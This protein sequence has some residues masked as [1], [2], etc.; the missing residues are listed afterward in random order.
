[1]FGIP[2][3]G[4]AMSLILALSSAPE[5]VRATTLYQ[6]GNSLTV[7]S[8]LVGI[9]AIAGLAG[10][11][12]SG[13]R[14]VVS[15]STLGEIWNGSTID[16][17]SSPSA[18][19]QQGLAGSLLDYVT[20]Q[21][22]NKGTTNLSSDT[23]WFER[24]RELALENSENAATR[25]YVYAPWPLRFQ[26]DIWDDEVVDSPGQSTR[27]SLAYSELLVNKLNE[28]PGANYGLIP[29]GQVLAEIRD[30]IAA[31]EI[32][33]LT[34]ISNL[35][36]DAIHMNGL[37][38][39]VAASTVFATIFKQDPTPLGVP[40]GVSGWSESNIPA[41]LATQLQSIVWEVVTSQILTGVYPLG[42]LDKNTLIDQGDYQFWR[43]Q[44]GFQTSPTADA[45]GDGTVDFDDAVL[46]LQ[47]ELDESGDYNGDGVTDSSDHALWVSEFGSVVGPAD[48]NNDGIVD[49][50]DYT[51]WRDA[52]GRIQAADFNGDGVADGA[53]LQILES[54][55]GWST[56]LTADA[57]NDGVVDGSD[58][59]LWRDAYEAQSGAPLA[60]PEPTSGGLALLALLAFC[61]RRP[62]AIVRAKSIS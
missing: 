43:S 47:A 36:R 31:D 17:S 26:W 22:F 41:E 57:N 9:E 40:E 48:G 46:W 6:V 39:F 1:M 54:Q 23:T 53:D 32:P 14:T 58:Y 42:D 33:G 10:I 51:I 11:D 29:V 52:Y 28:I 27:H 30:Q 20:L 25:F 34:S 21:F 56:E 5:A 19:L 50:A 2:R 16:P 45:N 3:L 18:E 13:G 15:N 12:L 60:V 61:G 49:A 4:C 35:Y 38:N 7:D 8:N 24:Y 44:F 59:T 55:M 37:G 62:S